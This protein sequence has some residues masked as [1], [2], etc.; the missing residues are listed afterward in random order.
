MDSLRRNLEVAQRVVPRIGSAKI[1]RSWAGIVRETPDLRP[2]V[3]PIESFP[4]AVVGLFP[5]MGLTAGP[6]L[7]KTLADLTMGVDPC[8]DLDPFS[9]NRF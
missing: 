1:L 8:F 4:G 2:I 5:H 9:P 3:G 7:G 6:L